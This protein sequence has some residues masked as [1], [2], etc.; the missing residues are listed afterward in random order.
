M[1]VPQN[2]NEMDNFFRKKKNLSLNNSKRIDKI[3][4]A[5]T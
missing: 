1:Y 5:K 3:K 4:K 2:L